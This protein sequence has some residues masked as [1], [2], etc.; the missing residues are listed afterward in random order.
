MNSH[1]TLAN[2]FTTAVR[3]K[4][5]LDFDG[6][7]SKVDVIDA[8]LEK[9]ADDRWLEV[10]SDWVSGKI[11]SR[12]CLQKQFSYVKAA[13]E[14][15][16]GFVDTL[17]IDQG[18]NLVMDFCRTAQITFHIVSDG[19]EQYIRRMLHRYLGDT[20]LKD[21]VA[22]SANSLLSTTEGRW[23]T[24][25]PYF[26][27]SCQ[28]GCATCKPALM[29]LYNPASANIIFVGDG[30]SDR[31]AAAEATV[32][33]AKSKLADYC[34]TNSIPYISYQTLED[35]ATH[36]GK[37]SNSA[38]YNIPDEIFTFREAI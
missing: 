36:L 9:F 28:D 20:P 22:I 10:E 29:K 23:R 26:V 11:G 3:P 37:A 33:F 25:F 35:I 6:T 27:E 38:G 21:D 15:L 16:F 5:F 32:V 12:E 24:A 17:D 14:D 7:I 4:M 31:F 34:E 19:F 30:L 13:P 8:I 1:I 2:L 18:F